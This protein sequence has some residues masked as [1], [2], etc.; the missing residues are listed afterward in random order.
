LSDVHITFAIIAA[1]VVLFV[2]NRIPVAVVA[3]GTS[4]A[5]YLTG[6]LGAGEAVEGL[7]DPVV[8]FIASLF[9]IT[10]GLEATGVT[11]WAGQLLVR[12]AGGSPTRLLAFL[13]MLAALL[14]AAMGFIGT[15]ASLLPVAVVAAV[16][17]GVP[18]SQLLMPLAFSASASG[19]LTLTASP[20][21]VLMANAVADAG[22][23]EFGFFEFALAGVPLV[24]GTV[25]LLL[26]LGRRLLPNR[27]GTAMPAD[28]SDH[29]RRLVEQYG[30]PDDL[31]RLRVRPTSPYV[32]VARTDLQLGRDTD[33]QLVSIE[34]GVAA[35]GPQRTIAPGDVLVV[36]GD[37]AAADRLAEVRQLE[38]CEKNPSFRARRSSAAL[39]VSLKSSS[40]P[41]RA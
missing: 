7:G 41:G 3:V 17:L 35:R 18:T 5:L 10:A 38:I 32:G 39:P 14:T 33:V 22:L 2:W 23:P 4:L 9:V 11:T 13:M 27:D 15:V 26:L 16:R 29:A 12:K 1:V 28:F 34:S 6:V 31:H 25:I 36:R 21:N 8:V 24:L 19:L 30:L 20:V 37:A 40:R